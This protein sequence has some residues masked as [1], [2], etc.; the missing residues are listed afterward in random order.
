M[1]IRVSIPSL[2]RPSLSDK[3][4]TGLLPCAAIFPR[5]VHTKARQVTRSLLKCCLSRNEK[6]SSS[7][8]GSPRGLTFTWWGCYGSCLRHKPTEL[9]HTFY[10]VLVS[11][12]V[13]MALSTV[14]HS[15]NSPDNSPL[16]HSVLLVLLCLA[17]PFNYI[18]L[19]ESLPQP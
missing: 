15:I 3:G 14:F 10:S 1:A 2:I 7:C 18:S 12:S 6:S 8:L 19:Y 16:S 17:G 4:K 9:A 11:V 13:F 5:A